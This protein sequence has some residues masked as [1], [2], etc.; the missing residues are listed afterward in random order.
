[1]PA[2][3]PWLDQPLLFAIDRGGRNQRLMR[4]FPHASAWLER[5]GALVRHPPIE[6]A[7]RR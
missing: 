2:N 1:M 6:P 3:S 4:L 5:D 7:P